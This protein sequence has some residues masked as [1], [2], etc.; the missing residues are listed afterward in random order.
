MNAELSKLEDGLMDLEMLLQDALQAG[1]EKFKERVTAL[2]TRQ[3]TR[4]D[5]FVNEEITELYSNFHREISSHLA[6]E[7]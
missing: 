3:K 4:T 2:I 7:M 5:G 6:D 1:T